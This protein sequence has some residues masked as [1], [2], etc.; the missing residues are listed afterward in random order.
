VSGQ[1]HAPAALPPGKDP[2]RTHWIGGWVGPR[3]GLDDAERRILIC[4][5]IVNCILR[6][7]IWWLSQQNGLILSCK[8]PSLLPPWLILRKVVQITRLHGVT[9]Q[10]MVLSKV[11]VSTKRLWAV[12]DF[13][14]GISE[15]NLFLYIS[16]VRGWLQTYEVGRGSLVDEC[17]RFRVACYLLQGRGRWIWRWVP[18]YRWYLST[19]ARDF[20]LLHNAKIGSGPQPA[21]LYNEHRELFSCG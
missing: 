9:F 4:W 21:L 2:S 18:L 7:V 17:W 13:S 8:P 5:V 12:A 11:R 14:F 16:T 19:R 10:K 6:K 1:L 3:T 20:S 15:I